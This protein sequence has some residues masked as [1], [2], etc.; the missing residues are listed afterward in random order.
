LNDSKILWEK[1]DSKKQVVFFIILLRY[2]VFS[3][4][5]G[6]SPLLRN[7]NGMTWVS[8]SVPHKSLEQICSEL[9]WLKNTFCFIMEV[10]ALDLA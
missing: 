5:L 7:S 1:V 9:D 3:D 4:S 8:N 6:F 10:A 2:W